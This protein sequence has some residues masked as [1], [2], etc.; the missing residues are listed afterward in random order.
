MKAIVAIMM[1]KVKKYIK[2]RNT[3]LFLQK[4]M[5]KKIFFKCTNI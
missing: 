4:I 1:E 5:N 3:F 2:T